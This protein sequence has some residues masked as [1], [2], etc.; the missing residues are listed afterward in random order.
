[1]FYG[2]PLIASA[3]GGPSEIVGHMATGLLVEN[4]NIAK[5]S[6]AMLSLATNPKLHLI[7][8]KNA[9]EHV[10]DKFSISN[11]SY[12]LKDIYHESLSKTS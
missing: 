7:F 11:T 5:M 6:E 2:R 4:R 12:V 9:G 1:M 10:R 8:S 3:C